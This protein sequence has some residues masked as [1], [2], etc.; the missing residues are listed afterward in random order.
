MQIFL[1]DAGVLASFRFD[2]RV[3]GVVGQRS[4]KFRDGL[5]SGAVHTHGN[6]LV[7][8]RFVFQPGASVG[9]DRRGEQFVIGLVYSDLVVRARGTDQLRDHDTLCAVVDESS[10]LR[11]Y[12]EIAHKD[13]LLLYLTGLLID[14]AYLNL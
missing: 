11:H 5:L 12:G 8:I 6:H 2:L 4:Q 10:L 7:G 13:F 3:Y 1:G 9:N 14:E